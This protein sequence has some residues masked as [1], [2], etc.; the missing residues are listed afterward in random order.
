MNSDR[1]LGPGNV[2][3]D[4]INSFENCTG[5]P[6]DQCF[7]TYL[8]L[9]LKVIVQ[10]V[11]FHCMEYSA[12]WNLCRLCC[13][14]SFCIY[15]GTGSPC[16]PSCHFTAEHPAAQSCEQK[17]HCS[18]CHRSCMTDCVKETSLVLIGTIM[19]QNYFLI[20]TCILAKCSLEFDVCFMKY[21]NF[22]A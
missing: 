11:S 14:F 19:R 6:S 3:K 16:H 4:P 13:L 22:V 15:K 5:D 21:C 12:V 1:E 2:C 17:G 8:T 10:L 18:V 20:A 9:S 7:K